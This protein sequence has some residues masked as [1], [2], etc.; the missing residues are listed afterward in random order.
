MR[1]Q[2]R[3]VPKPGARRLFY[4]ILFHTPLLP[5]ELMLIGGTPLNPA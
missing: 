3:R 5:R 4:S 2:Q 1:N